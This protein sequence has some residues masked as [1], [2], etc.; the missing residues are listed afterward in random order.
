ME[1]KMP[2]CLKFVAIHDIWNSI[3]EIQAKPEAKER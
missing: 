2:N 3:L 1:L